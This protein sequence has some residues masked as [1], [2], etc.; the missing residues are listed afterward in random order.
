MKNNLSD[1]NNF[2]FQ[3]LERLSD[4]ELGQEAM[5]REVRRTDAIVNIS[6]QVID[7]AKIALDAAELVAKHGVGRWED[8]LPAVENKP[9]S[10]GVA[11]YSKEVIK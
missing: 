6:K 5:E 1:L 7:N 2:L 9:K 10:P 3:Q 11:D 8:M 4:Q